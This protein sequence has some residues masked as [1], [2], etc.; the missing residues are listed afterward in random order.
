MRFDRLAFPI[1]AVGLAFTLW[2]VASLGR[3]RDA[4]AV[5]MIRAD[6]LISAADHQLADAAASA[7]L[8]RAVIPPIRMAAAYA[9]GGAPAR[10]SF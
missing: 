8:R 2:G 9:P 1:L 3:V 5:E 4:L 10:S 7:R 6:A